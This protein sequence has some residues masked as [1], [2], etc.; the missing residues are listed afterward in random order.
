MRS[1]P[2]W[3]RAT[4]T[5]DATSG[6]PRA[7]TSC[8]KSTRQDV[9]LPLSVMVFQRHHTRIVK[10]DGPSQSLQLRVGQRISELLTVCRRAGALDGVDGRL[11]SL[12]AIN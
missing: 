5:L 10:S 3:Q 1:S 9:R 12:I 6:R 8:A 11:Q 2:S 7:K 4:T